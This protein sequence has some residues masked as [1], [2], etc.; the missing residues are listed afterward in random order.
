MIKTFFYI[1]KDKLNNK[2]ELCIFAKIKLEGKSATLSTGR[3]ISKERWDF[4][5]KLKNTLKLNHEKNIRKS[6]DLIERKI[7]DTYYELSKTSH[8]V[9]VNDIKNK[10]TGKSNDSNNSLDI[11]KLFKMHNAYFKKKYEA[12]ERSGASLQKYDR[13]KDLLAN[14]INVKHQKT[15]FLIADIDNRFVYDLEAYLK[16][17]STFKGKIGISHNSVVK[18]FQS[19]KTVCKFGI[20]RNLINQNPF[21]IY[22]EK[23]VIKDAVFLTK[24]ELEKI[25]EKEFS[26]DR[27]NK[28]KDIFLFSCYT[29]YAPCDV[30]KLTKENLIEDNDNSLW[31]KTNRAKTNV[32]S[33]VPIIPPVKRIIDKYDHL[34][35]TL[36]PR[37]SNQKI[38]EYLKE[39]AI[40][41]GI[42]KKLC[43]Y[44]ARHT[45]ATTV[46]LGNGLS[47]ENVSKMMG[48]TRI[49]MT[50][51]YAKV[52]DINVKKDMDK[53]N[54]I[55]C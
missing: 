18:Y 33:N 17:E 37:I 49:T 36:L 47:I 2:G 44:V 14:F 30:E 31:I 5:N 54:E 10:I 15:S 11:L 39:I 16:Y 27:L 52:L 23:L 13:A 28:V 21:L 25:E 32:K 20:K 43:H 41:C 6:L 51:H 19:F 50:Q 45:F 40:L 35:E 46:T 38:N 34:D 8:K 22:D 55:Y 24:Q 26:T 7:E 29:G 1:K 48:H 42:D 12:G 9:T 3:F 53:L 4:T